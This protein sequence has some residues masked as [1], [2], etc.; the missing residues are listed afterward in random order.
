M[1]TLLW[2][3]PQ[4]YCTNRALAEAAQAGLDVIQAGPEDL[5]FST[6]SPY[7]MHADGRD[8]LALCD[9]ILIR[10]FA[11]HISEAITLAQLFEQAGKL[12][13][14]AA[15]CREGYSISKMHDYVQL[16]RQNI[17]VPR[18]TQPMTHAALLQLM[19]TYPTPFILKGIHGTGG[20][21]VH[22]VKDASA[23]QALI[24]SYPEGQLIWQEYLPAPYDWRVIVINGQALPVAVERRPVG[25]DFRTNTDFD[26]Q[27]RSVARTDNPAL[28]DLA[29]QA[30]RA[31]T[32]SFAGVDL[33][34]RGDELVVLEVNRRPGFQAFESCTG[35][36][37]AGA[38]LRMIHD[39]IVEGTTHSARTTKCSG[40]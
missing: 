5:C 34:Q 40:T 15:L 9:A 8:L 19:G 37:V 10:K 1:P 35:Y 14:D 3:E 24:A 16:S 38:V 29:E 36:N 22:L 20:K 6:Q 2:Y 31:L 32:R 26:N 13:F 21:H 25:D 39:Q 28:F 7:L 17:P 33:R 23:T 30:A 27:L 4:N 18:S 12:V 11:P